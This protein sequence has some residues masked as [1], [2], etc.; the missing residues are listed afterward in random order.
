MKLHL[1]NA[2]FVSLAL[3]L[4]TT[5]SSAKEGMWQPSKIKAQEAEMK[6]MGLQMQVEDLY[7]EKGTGLNNAVVIFG[8]GCTG[9]FV[10]DQGLIFTNHHCAYGTAQSLSTPEN[11]FLDQ[12]FFA[13]NKGEEI[14]C[15]GLTVQIVK[16]LE[17][18]TK[19]ILK[20]VHDSLSEDDRAKMI[21][22]RSADLEK[23]YQKLY[24]AETKIS[25]YFEGNEYWIATKE[26]YSDVRLVAFPPNGIG[27]FGADTDNW[28]W[29]R[30][31]GD[32]AVLRVYASKD[33]KPANYSP[34][35]VPFKPARFFPINVA[36]IQEGDFTMVYGYPG[37]TMQYLSS[38]Q[39]DQVQNVLDPIRIKARTEKLDIWDK[40]MRQDKTT[41]LKYASKQSS[42]ANGWKK[43]QGEVM[44]LSQ[45]N[46][47]GK[48]QTTE[49]TF[50]KQVGQAGNEYDR[51]LLTNLEANVKGN[52][53]LVETTEYIRE[54]VLAIEAVQQASTLQQVLN[55]YRSNM[56]DV[57]V[58]DSLQKIK[59]RLKG[60][61]KNYI[62]TVDKDVFVGLMPMYLEQGAPV[63]PASM[64]KL[65]YEN[66]NKASV[67]AGNVYSNS[68]VPNGTAMYAFLDKASKADS[69]VILNDPAYQIYNA[70]NTYQ[71]NE[72]T[73]KL[74]ANQDK[75]NPLFRNY[76]KAQMQYNPAKKQLYPDA[77]STLRIAYGNVT[78]IAQAEGNFFVTNL[79]DLV[80]RNNPAVEE[81]N[82]PAKLL[83]LHKTK[84]YGRWATNGTVPVNFIATNH[85]T[86]GNS[87]SPVLNAK[88]QLI[89]INFDRIWQGTMSDIYFDE[90]FCR[91]VA[92]DVRYVLFILEKYG[93]A[94]WLFK[95][96]KIVD[97]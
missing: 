63:V 40:H 13:Q 44:G 87:G 78:P 92:V 49:S 73:P 19:F 11:N 50:A 35:N 25:A 24:G 47:I 56:T 53:S 33:N 95:E 77:N 7:N 9:E 69:T 32:F 91:N 84:N 68:L 36:G 8:G 93:N 41:F 26:T 38:F 55:V 29:P 4:F 88:G 22:Q 5:S 45:N 1:R 71:K 57:A 51:M 85:T 3:T 28:M 54:T 18:V 97:K 39:V 62:P 30:Q 80:P 83:D 58:A 67:W 6:K 12:G 48:K 81:F 65:A 17:N 42:V 89:G 72:I 66:G 16:K 20:D 74:K 21:K 14:P 46:V 82:I 94:S 37:R 52:N 70:V 59:T 75:L 23:S 27:K 10:S 31:T 76:V 79:D 15:P 60:F 34:D 2:V 86:G 64:N 96:M 61:Y 90:S 43:W